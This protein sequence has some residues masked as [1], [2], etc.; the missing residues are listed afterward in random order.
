[1]FTFVFVLHKT[2]PFSVMIYN[3]WGDP[4]AREA[5]LHALD[6]L[7]TEYAD[8]VC[9]PTTQATLALLVNGTHV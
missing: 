7:V 8:G 9:L 3:L 5:R 6:L 2:H 4:T 1:M